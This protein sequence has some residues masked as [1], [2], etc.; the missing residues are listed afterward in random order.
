M[1][2]FAS[3]ETNARAV[4][5]AAVPVIESLSLKALDGLSAPRSQTLQFEA[6]GRRPAGTLATVASQSPAFQGFA[7]YVE[8]PA[9]S[10]GSRPCVK[11]S[12]TFASSEPTV[13]DFVEP[14]ASGSSFPKLNASGHPIP[15][16]AS[17]LFCAYNPGTTIV[18]IT[19]GLLQY[20][21]PVTVQPGNIG[22]PCGTVTPKNGLPKDYVVGTQTQG[23]LNGA[24]APP[25]PPPAA[26]S[27]VNP[28]ISFV[29]PPPAAQ[30]PPAAP[31]A[32]TPVVAKTPVEPIPQVPQAPVEQVGVS[33]AIVPPA[34]PPVEPIPPGG[35][36]Q[37]PSAA[38]RKEKA[39]KHAS[40][41]ASF[42][43]RPAGVSAEDWFF[44]AV[45]ITGLLAVLLC[46]G[47]LPSSPGPRPAWLREG[48]GEAQR[49]PRRR[50]R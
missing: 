16:S 45:G 47:A 1:W 13:G 18:S 10:C 48:V 43:T 2:Y 28:T 21:L 37:A 30:A 11:P 25:P 34:T 29:P 35:T 6:I 7:N 27:G 17:G 8:I 40:Q 41:S 49:R 24:A 22:Q 5:V 36:A 4:K 26:L 20:S 46:M 9:P 33:P 39:R 31:P 50:R 44:P 42:V 19:V 12:Y 32:V 23:K 3:I 14:A 15:S 38:E